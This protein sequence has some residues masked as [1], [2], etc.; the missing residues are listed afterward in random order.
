M[1]GAAQGP[2]LGHISTGQLQARRAATV[3]AVKASL[4]KQFAPRGFMLL[5]QQQ[6]DKLQA[7]YPLPVFTTPAEFVLR[8]RMLSEMKVGG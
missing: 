1:Q 7:E 4:S 8:S 5:L 3:Q 6:H 2:A